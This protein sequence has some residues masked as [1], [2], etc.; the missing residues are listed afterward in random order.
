MRAHAHL[1]LRWMQRLVLVVSTCT[2]LLTPGVVASEATAA[3]SAVSPASV[4]LK[5][6]DLP[7]WRALVSQAYPSRDLI[8]RVDPSYPR[9]SRPRDGWIASFNRK[10]MS[11]QAYIADALTPQAAR[12]A[13][14]HIHAQ[15]GSGVSP[16][17]LGSGGW[18]GVES[19]LKSDSGVAWANGRY[20]I[21]LNLSTLAPNPGLTRSQLLAIA[22]VM[23]RRAR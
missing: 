21:G 14:R 16:V 13:V 2:A 20:V 18:Y 1:T 23:D 3:R 5:P 11:L 9:G 15:Q 7:A 12:L 17:A 6:G 8:Q 4:M 19:G 10:T 22:R